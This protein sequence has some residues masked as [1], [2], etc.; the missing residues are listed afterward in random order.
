MI[1]KLRLKL[2]LASMFSLL[3][4]LLVIIGGINVLNVYQVVQRADMVLD[5]LENHD[6]QLPK[7]NNLLDE[8][9][10]HIYTSPEIP[11]ESR[12]FSVLLTDDGVTLSTDTAQIA[13]VDQEDAIDF[14]QDVLSLDQDRGFIDDYRYTIQEEKDGIRI[15][16]LD[17]GRWMDTCRGFLFSSLFISFIGLT[18]V[19]ILI[20]LLS[21]RIIKPVSDSYEKQRRFITDAGHE[22]KTPLAIIDADAG[23]AESE[24]GKSE[25]LDD[26]QLQVRRLTELTNDLI[27]LS[28]MEE[29]RDQLVFIDFP[30]SD[31][32]EESVRSF[33]ALAKKQNKTF[34][35]QIQPLLS[36]HGDSKSIGQLVSI[37][38]DNAV[39][40]SEEN[41]EIAVRL[42]KQGR[43]I[44]LSVFNTTKA[45]HKEDLT[46]LFDRF[47]RADKSRNSQTGGYGIGLSIASAVVAAHK[48]KITASSK[49]GKSLEITVTLPT[50]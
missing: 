24:S 13:A 23:L 17:C 47:Y 19:C 16:F 1:K 25:W 22:I 37:L 26:I 3:V 33:Q 8:D 34:S 32:V 20:T 18:A 2:I 28:K 29:A 15:I 41:G 45:I 46:H 21:S 50:G 5:I 39:K 36:L 10:D 7:L 44:R 4:V 11:Y 30:I 14:A 31:L 38:L 6:G 27:Y 35:S 12:Y 49:D 42:E 43:A 48:G 40:Y 9:G